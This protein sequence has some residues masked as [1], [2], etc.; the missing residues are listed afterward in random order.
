MR[1][2]TLQI[3]GQYPEPVNTG[4]M[5]MADLAII[6]RWERSLEPRTYYLKLAPDHEP[7]ALK[8]HLEPRAESDLHLTWVAQAIPDVVVYLQLAIFA[9]SAILIG[10]AVVNVFNT[11]LLSV[12]EKLRAVGVL[13]TLGMTP[14]QV[15]AMI[16][17]TAGVL[18]VLASVVGIPLGW[19]LTKTMLQSLSATYGFGRAHVAFRPLY[20]LLLPPLMVGVSLL[21]SLLPARRAARLSIVSVLRQG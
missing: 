9:L 12:Q 11:S 20:G 14:G 8:A 2:L 19:W 21:G 18:A 17:T 10:I 6:R 13:K 15:V 16:G 1:P 7:A 4:E 5:L 3:V